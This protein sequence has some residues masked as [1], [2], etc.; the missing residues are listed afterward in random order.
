MGSEVG[1]IS[2]LSDKIGISLPA[3]SLPGGMVLLPWTYGVGTAL[4]VVL[5]AFLLAFS[6]QSVG[7]AYHILSKV[8]WWARMATGWL[9]IVVGVYFSIQYVFEVL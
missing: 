7:K 9:F 1:E 2:S 5:I 3:A 6:A 8:E 4:P